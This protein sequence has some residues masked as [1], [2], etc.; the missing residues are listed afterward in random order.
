MF[1]GNC[2]R[3]NALVAALR[4][5]GHDVLMVPVYLPLTLDEADESAGTPVFF[6]GISVYLEQE[7]ALFRSTPDWL[8][9]L[10]A[11][12]RLLKWAGRMA[13]RT[14]ASKLGEMTLSML[15]GEHGNQ[16]AELRMLSR[17]LASQ[18]PPDL[19][20]FSNALLLG[21][22]HRL[23]TDFKTRIACFLQGEDTFLDALSEP[24]RTEAWQTVASLAGEVDVFVSPSHYFA[25]LMRQRLQLAE[26]KVNVVWNGI[27]LEGYGAQTD[28][29][30]TAGAA[31]PV[32]GYFARMCREKGL[33]TLVS[34]FILIRQR[35]RVPNLKLKIGGSC[36][37]AD[38][39]L[40]KELREQ[41]DAAG[42]EDEVEF[43]RNPT[44]TDKL[45][46]LRSLSVFS[47]PANYGEAFGLYLI[48]A[49][50]AGIPVVQPRRGSFPE[51]IEATG[52]G[53]LCDSEN[54]QA[55]AETIEE[56]LLNPDEA[57][58]LGH[59]GRRSVF[60][61]FSADIMAGNLIS[62]LGKI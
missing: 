36:G 42:L 5:L 50:A 46:F 54:P 23:R 6:G 52:G 18:P 57:K 33:D 60:Q 17:W 7:A 14:R 27:N 8:R 10:L 12:R 16:A 44:R 39:P 19:I 41:L 59:A 56:L 13:N 26:N 4:R 47:V 28:A 37:P 40:V 51:L 29:M 1:C 43:H 32:L 15:R 62:A 49:L 9:Q 45:D 55:L 24:Y 25:G 35:G 53:R 2:L 34:A 58:S 61:K 31:P 22:A 3:D 20:C 38:E 30:D 11:S 48:E 21:M